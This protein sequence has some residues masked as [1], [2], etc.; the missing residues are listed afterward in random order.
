MRE[1]TEKAMFVQDGVNYVGW[2]VAVCEDKAVLVEGNAMP[3]LVLIQAPYAPEKKGM[4]Y[5]FTPYME[6]K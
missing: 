5:L 2:D 1:V 3:D 4:K 6:D